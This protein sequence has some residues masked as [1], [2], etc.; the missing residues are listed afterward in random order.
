MIKASMPRQG[1]RPIRA[2]ART[3]WAC[4]RWSLNFVKNSAGSESF[5]K[6]RVKPE[7]STGKHQKQPEKL[8]DM[9]EIASHKPDSQARAQNYPFRPRSRG[10]LGVLENQTRLE[11]V[12][13]WWPIGNA[14]M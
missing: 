10:A 3:G 9:E 13:D 6:H 1:R 12:G 14:P 2:T 5:R 7:D 8:G 4:S 11:S